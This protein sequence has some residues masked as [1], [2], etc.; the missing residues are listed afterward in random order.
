MVNLL[1]P[2]VR[3]RI[4][5]TL[6]IRLALGNIGDDRA[7]GPEIVVRFGEPQAA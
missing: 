2:G 6:A 4:A 1:L 5:V 7:A 3:G